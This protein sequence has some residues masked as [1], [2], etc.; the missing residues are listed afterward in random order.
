MCVYCCSALCNAVCTLSPPLPLLLSELLPLLLL[1]YHSSKSAATVTTHTVYTLQNLVSKFHQTPEFKAARKQD[2][3]ARLQNRKGGGSSLASSKF[4]V[5][6]KG[7]HL[8]SSSTSSASRRTD[9]GP[10]PAFLQNIASLIRLGTDTTAVVAAAVGPHSSAGSASG[11][12]AGGGRYAAQ[13]DE[14]DRIEQQLLQF[15]HKEKTEKIVHSTG[16]SQNGESYSP[17][18]RSKSRCSDASFHSSVVMPD[19]TEQQ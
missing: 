5:S 2:K 7:R 6:P 9:N 1:L 4:S 12:G 8:S 17:I 14:L 19:V 18:H 11:G 16:S 13:S 15:H 10:T 3:N